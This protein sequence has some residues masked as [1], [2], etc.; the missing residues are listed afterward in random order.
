MNVC[1]LS[2]ELIDLTIDTDE[3]KKEILSF[4]PSYSVLQIN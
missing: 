3:K 2:L 1:D 4:F